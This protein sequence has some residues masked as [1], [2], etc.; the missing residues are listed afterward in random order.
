MTELNAKD[1]V[2]AYQKHGS[3]KAVGRA[4]GIS[5]SKAHK[6][7]LKA[8]KA[9]L[10]LPIRV[11]RKSREDL[12]TP[13]AMPDFTVQE[14][15]I[16]MP[17][18]VPP[19]GEVKRYLF[20]CAQNNT[21][22]HAEFWRNLLAYATHVRAEIHV[23]RFAYIKSGLGARGDKA[24]MWETISPK[25]LDWAPEIQAHL[26]DK[27]V[28]VAPGLTW[29]GEM[30][31][32]PTAVRPLS[33]LDVYT[34]R[35][36]GIF[37]HPKIAMESIAS[38]D[39]GRAKFNYTTGACTVHNYIQ[40]KAGLKAQFHHSIGALF[41]EVSK[42]GWWCRQIHANDKDGDFYDLDCHVSEGKVTP[43]QNVLAVTWG[44][45]H[46]I[47]RDAELWPVMDAMAN[48]LKPTYQFFHDVISFRG[49]SHHNRNRPHQK[50]KMHC[51]GESSVTAEICQAKAI[52]LPMQKWAEVSVIVDSN[53]HHH[54][55]RWLEEV[56]GMNDPGNVQI[57]L[58]MNKA[59]IEEIY[60]GYQPLYLKLA[61]RLVDPSDILW[62][63]FCW[64]GDGEGFLIGPPDHKIECGMHGDYGPNGSRGSANNL[65][66]LGHRSNVGHSHTARI[67]DGV[68]QAGT[69]QKIPADWAHGPSAWSHSHIVTYQNGRRAIVTMWK[70][71]WR[72]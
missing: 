17:L 16:G 25:N 39:Y 7:Y 29:C 53:H 67:V 50:F 5:W 60:R 46:I 41:V 28:E 62:K 22:V 23:S 47:E 3:I 66:K 48:H 72:A 20:T 54:I 37:P 58:D 10:I 6:S 69:C 34:G 33:G 59:A 4:L 9:G 71:K 57:W 52:L 49:Q 51:A 18:P 19:S 40:R 15:V 30:N 55:G 14:P 70:G 1:F 2:A 44:D 11:G 45:L 24:E 31:I 38:L 27:Q 64:L 68:Y 42:D 65:A 12:K 21:P 43:D 36:S 63:L 8:R 32:L 13:L 26:S 35:T 56:N 61:F